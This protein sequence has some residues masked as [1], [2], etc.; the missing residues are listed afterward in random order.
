MR[1]AGG[2]DAAGHGGHTAANESFGSV[3]VA[4]FFGGFRVYLF[5]RFW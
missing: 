2:P 4:G 3:G 5:A 1:L